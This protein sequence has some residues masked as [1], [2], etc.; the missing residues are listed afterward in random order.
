LTLA[1]A[2]PGQREIGNWPTNNWGHLYP[3]GGWNTQHSEPKAAAVVAQRVGD[4]ITR[5]D[6][7]HVYD[8]IVGQPVFVEDEKFTWSPEELIENTNR[9]GWFQMMEPEFEQCTVFGV[10]DTT[11][12]TG[13]GGG[14]VAEDGDYIFA[15]WRPYTCCEISDGFLIDINFIDFPFPEIT[16]E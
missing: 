15:L 4:I 10:D 13:W 8:D 2:I 1:A 6:E 9:E 11:D 7:P 16:N 3:R 14:R 5:E 12:T